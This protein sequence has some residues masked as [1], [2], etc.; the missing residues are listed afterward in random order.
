MA[1]IGFGE[2]RSRVS[3]GSAVGDRSRGEGAEDEDPGASDWD[4][5]D[6]TAEGSSAGMAALLETGGGVV[7]SAAGGS[8][9]VSP[10]TG[11][12][13]PSLGIGRGVGRATY[14]T[15]EVSATDCVERAAGTSSEVVGR[16]WLSS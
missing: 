8:I 3:C 15:A 11:E 6:A 10:L 1:S 14:R 2:S 13:G 12:A 7:S 9:A 16:A 4:G 5:R